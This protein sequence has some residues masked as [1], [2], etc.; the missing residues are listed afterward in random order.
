MHN[1]PYVIV[2]KFCSMATET[3]TILEDINVEADDLKGEHTQTR[4]LV[5]K[6]ETRKVK[7]V[8]SLGKRAAVKGMFELQ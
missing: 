7:V 4:E 6:G 3:V 2:G 5:L 8:V 1:R